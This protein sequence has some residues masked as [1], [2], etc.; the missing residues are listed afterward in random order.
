MGLAFDLG[1]ALV[2]AGLEGLAG[3]P[4]G[5]LTGLVHTHFRRCLH[6]AADS[7]RSHGSRER[8]VPRPAGPARAARRRAGSDAPALPGGVAGGPAGAAGLGQSLAEP[9][10]SLS[11]LRVVPG[12]DRVP[13][14]L[15][16]VSLAAGRRARPAPGGEL[17]PARL[18]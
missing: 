10:R 5:R 11:P 13:A 18:L 8:R 14:P 15:L 9:G 17:V 4:G 6:P 12:P 16:H 3:G 1:R 2:S 7:A